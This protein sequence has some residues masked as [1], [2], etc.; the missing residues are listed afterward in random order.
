MTPKNKQHIMKMQHA[1][2]HIA[3]WSQ[4]KFNNVH[5][6]KT[7]HKWSVGPIKESTF[8][9][10]YIAKINWVFLL[11]CPQYHTK[12]QAGVGVEVYVCNDFPWCFP[13]APPLVQVSKAPFLPS[14]PSFSSLFYSSF[15][16]LSGRM[17]ANKILGPEAEGQEGSRA[18][19]QNQVH[20]L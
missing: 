9:K 7:G 12:L 15:I 18:K 3:K 17:D 4:R 20:T 6:H 16:F 10:F 14:S 5:S 2:W 1:Y 11:I 19:L 13:L 8:V